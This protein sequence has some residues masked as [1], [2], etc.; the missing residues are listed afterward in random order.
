MCLLDTKGNEDLKLICQDKE[1]KTLEHKCKKLLE[2]WKGRTRIPTWEP[3][4]QALQKV[5]L[6]NLA[7]E[8]KNA[9]FN[10]ERHQRVTN[11]VSVEDQGINIVLPHLFHH[12]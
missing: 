7:G 9:A 11:Q 4:I 3:V 5:G 10:L 8:I 1:V 2:L 6:H 12:L